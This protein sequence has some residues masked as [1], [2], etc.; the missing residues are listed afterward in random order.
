MIQIAGNANVFIMHEAINFRGGIDKTA[1][2]VRVILKKEPMDGA[3][4]VFRSKLGHSLRI[5]YYDGSGFWLC[6]KRLSSGTFNKA[7]PKGSDKGSDEVAD[8]PILVREL[9]ILIW[10]ADPASCQFPESWRRAS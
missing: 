10:G 6:T 8:S 1:A 3:H 7:W 2:V 5:L 4:F 9:Q